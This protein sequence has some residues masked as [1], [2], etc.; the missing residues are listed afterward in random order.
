[1]EQA[2]HGLCVRVSVCVCACLS[3][4]WLRA[5][6]TPKGKEGAGKDGK[7]ERAERSRGGPASRQTHY[8]PNKSQYVG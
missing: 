2:P 3:A 4:G 7:T 6:G 8:T 1:M 5:G